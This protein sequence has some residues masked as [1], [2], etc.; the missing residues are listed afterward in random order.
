[1]NA[2]SEVFILCQESEFELLANNL[3]SFQLKNRGIE[4]NGFNV[5]D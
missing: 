5:G 2:N 3:T 1:M 4:Q